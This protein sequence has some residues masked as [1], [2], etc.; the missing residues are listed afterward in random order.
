MQSTHSEAQITQTGQAI[1]INNVTCTQLYELFS[2]MFGPN[3]TIKALVNGGQQLN[4]TK[5]GNSLCRDIQFTH[6][7]SILITRAAAS[8]Y[9]TTGDGTISFILMCC[10]AFN[11]SYKFYCDGT[12]ISGIIN[13]LQLS[14]KDAIQFLQENIIPLDDRTLRELALCSLRTKVRNPEFLADI[15]IKALSSTAASKSFDTDMVEVIKMEG[16]DI[17]DSIFID[18]LV[19]DHAGRHY[20]MPSELENV[21]VMVSNMSLE[22]EKPEVNAEFCYSSAAQR[23]ALAESER[24]FI[25]EKARAIA[26]FALELKKEGKSMILVDE[27]GIDPFSLEVLSE[28]GVLALRRA[29]RRNLERLINM[30]GGRIITQVSQINRECLGHCKKVTVKD[31]GDNK[32]TFIE[33]TPIRG[34]CTILLR[35]NADYE[36]LN[37]SIRGALHSLFLA[38]QSKCCIN[39]GVYFYRNMIRHL[40]QRL[41]TVHAA[42]AV[43]YKVLIGV[44]ENLIK[45]LFRNKGQSIHESMVTLFR[46]ETPSESVVENLKVVGNVLNNSIVTAINLLMCDE[47]IKAGKAIKQDKLE[48]Q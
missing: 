15:V 36:R 12:S 11:Q 22:Y 33:G 30:C 3:G 44:Y 42:D 5:D 43:G 19:L 27:K 13:S 37:K 40:T 14:L 4:L 35:G 18:G 34:A 24:E 9:T 45:T 26:S 10:D 39:G 41:E 8:L 47:I 48:D 32:F 31:F 17:R 20:A 6:P 7:T 23:D 16:G 21:C 38:I 25:L 28:A 46:E 1:A 29:K 2:P